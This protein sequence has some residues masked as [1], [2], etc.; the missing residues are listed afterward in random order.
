MAGQFGYIT[1]YDWTPTIDVTA[2]T[3]GDVLAAVEE[4]TLIL[5][6]FVAN[7]GG[8]F[9]S[10]VNLTHLANTATLDVGSIDIVLFDSTASLGTEGSGITIS[11]A[12][13]KKR[14]ATVSLTTSIDMINSQTMEKEVWVPL[15][16]ATQVQSLFAGLVDRS[17][18]DYVAATDIFIRFG[19]TH[20]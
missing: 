20:T 2:G 11:D 9:L 17:G 10:Y 18:K 14:L 6:R 13:A 1:M 5:P 16:P 4:L 3:T 15:V 19:I 8:S 7:Q 12:D